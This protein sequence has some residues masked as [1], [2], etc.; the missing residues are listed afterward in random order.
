MEFYGYHGLFNEEKKLGQ[1]FIV[2]AE[3]ET[4][5][6]KAGTTD[7]MEDSIN[8]GNVYIHIK[9]I[10]EGESKDLIEAVAED[11]ATRLLNTFPTLK[12][13]LIKV[14]KPNPPIQGH[15]ESVAVEIYRE[16]KQ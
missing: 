1:R 12:A 11:I 9:E 4:S 13:C 15:Y 16:R 5:L 6:Q 3:L 8:Y 2:D 10:V 14:I 7:N